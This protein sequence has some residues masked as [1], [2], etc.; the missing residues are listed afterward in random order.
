MCT[1]TSSLGSSHDGLW[2][3]VE[4]AKELLLDFRRLETSFPISHSVVGRGKDKCTRYDSVLQ[5]R[6]IIKR[7]KMVF[8]SKKSNTNKR[9]V[10]TWEEF[11]HSFPWEVIWMHYP[12]LSLN[13]AF[14]LY[15]E[16]NTCA[17]QVLYSYTGYKLSIYI[18]LLVITSLC[19]CGVS[20]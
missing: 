18:L 5:T 20:F 4:Q 1:Q 9:P 16:M 3:W 2:S 10:M 12:H 13:L 6:Q 19:I 17:E 14:A 11:P 15:I 7:F 8:P